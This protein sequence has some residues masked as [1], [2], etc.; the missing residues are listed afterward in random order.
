MKPLHILVAT[1]L[2]AGAAGACRSGNAQPPDNAG[3]ATLP[4]P[5]DAP[6]ELD[7]DQDLEERRDH[8]E[9]LSAADPARA[10]LRQELAEEYARRI[11][12]ALAE[13]ERRYLAHEGL[14]DLASLW[15]P[16]E[17]AQGPA[18]MAAFQAPALAVR[19]SFAR[20][21]G[22]LEA[23]AALFF[24]AAADPARAGAYLTEV[25]EIFTY[26][27]DLAVARYG[28]GA[29][30]ARPIEILEA[31]LDGL[32]TPAVVDRLVVRYVARQE[33]LV[34]QFHRQ[35]LSTDLL[36]A[37]GAGVFRT[38]WY[39]VR[40]MARAGRLDEAPAALGK[41]DGLGDDAAL[42]EAL[43]SA[44]GEG[45]EPARWLAL[46]AA[47]Q[48]SDPDKADP[49]AALSIYLEGSR[50]LPR[51]PALLLAAAATA[52]ELERYQQAIALYERGLELAPDQREATES[53]AALYRHRVS[54]LAFAE[55]PLAARARLA[56]LEGFL[57]G[58]H[59]RW[60]EEPLES[61][62]AAAYAAMGR[63]LVG[64]GDLGEARTYLQRSLSLRPT[65]ESLETLGMV[66]LK[67]DRF[68]EALGYFE[69]ALGMPA[70]EVSE[71]FERAKI[72]RLTGDAL[73]G[74]G[75]GE[76][77]ATRW[78]QSVD[79]WM[80]LAASVELP[81]RFK[82]E[83]LIEAAKAQWAL[84]DRNTGISALESAVDAD[85]DGGD[86]YTT[87]AS[88]LI[89]RG[90]YDRALDAY[91]RALGSH[92]VGDYTKVYLSLWMLAEARRR[93][94]PVDPLASE[95]L[96][97]RTG[98]LWYDA[99]ARFAVGLID[100]E[101]LREQATTRGRL[102]ELWYYTAV[103]GNTE[104]P[105]ERQRLLRSVLGTGMVLFFEYDMAKHW[106]ARNPGRS[107][108]RPP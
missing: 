45:S 55:R 79:A 3:L 101:A 107:G 100:Q 89:P 6:Y 106:L 19:D 33:G 20:S 85:P 71:Q 68:D 66:A 86:T 70:K 56:E 102:A 53:L 73:A 88:F 9:A 80:E 35:G 4:P 24:L 61:D 95:Y 49:V 57:A 41:V 21:G 26:A 1:A 104:N 50:R 62:L 38:T 96:A 77:A 13:P 69:R 105:Q 93:G 52:R 42:R 37:H 25:D 72:L 12:A 78:K 7:Y 11:E 31:A 29:E 32:P 98:R 108:H 91:H 63:G 30:N 65:Y 47:F 23:A 99:L 83:L 64:L 5:A 2:L 59:A 90:H 28:Q 103:L 36:R 54:M 97:S 22:D 43:A 94:E 46:G 40:A 67:Q 75:R 39:I 48:D 8:Y 16:H 18:D 10:R 92:E 87:V 76:Q 34:E 74:L 82:A 51:N 44:L 15:T 14:L 58:A 27:D 84:G 81:P 60:P 17:L